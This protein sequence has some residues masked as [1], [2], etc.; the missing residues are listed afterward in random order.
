[1]HHLHMKRREA[2]FKLIDLSVLCVT[3]MGLMK[4]CRSEGDLFF[5][6]GELGSGK[7]SLA[8]A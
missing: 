5:L 1:M 8:A 2:S 7:T 6:R 4:K 3:R